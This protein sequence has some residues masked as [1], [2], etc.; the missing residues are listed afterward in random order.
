MPDRMQ[1]I[2]SFCAAAW[3][4]VQWLGCV[5]QGDIV[6]GTGANP[7]P[8]FPIGPSAPLTVT[9]DAAGAGAAAGPPS[10]SPTGIVPPPAAAGGGT[11]GPSG[12]A[13]TAARS[14][15]SM[16]DADAGPAVSSLRGSSGCGTAPM[17]P[18][19]AVDGLP[20]SFLLDVPTSYDK[21]RPYPLVLA[22]R[23]M[24]AS[25]ETFRSQLN[26][27]SVADAIIAYPDPQDV[28]WQ[29]PRDVASVDEL[30]AQLTQNYCVDMDRMFAIG[31]GTG[32]LFAN[33]L[34]CVRG[35]QLRAIATLSNT[36]PPLGPCIGET[37]V[38]L[39]QR[40]DGDPMMVGS[41]YANRDFWTRSNA[42]DPRM[43]KPV[44]PAACIEFRSCSPGTAVRSCEYRGPQWP[45]YAISSAWEFL[46]SF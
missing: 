45:T 26:L 19:A 46:S 10:F 3:L 33:M 36:P 35:D 14:R 30:T 17:Q 1:R 38:W 32:A 9:S 7:A 28:A 34:G 40:T 37:A 27:A 22:F 16:R 4:G 11:R 29:F 24:D 6:L 23:N 2:F 21:T 15:P 18:E 43:P 20:A 31:D 44:P 5:A 41:G 13:S 25:A 8:D 12:P 39:L 42:C